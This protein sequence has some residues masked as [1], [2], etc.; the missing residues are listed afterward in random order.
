MRSFNNFLESQKYG[1]LVDRTARIMVEQQIDPDHYMFNYI[2]KN[3]PEV[4]N[5]N[6][7][8][9]MGTGLKNTWQTMKSGFMAN[10]I[11]DYRTVAKHLNYW[12]DVLGQ[13]D[14][15]GKL[16]D[17]AEKAMDALNQVTGGESGLQQISKDV[18]TRYI[19]QNPQA[20]QAQGD[21]QGQQGGQQNAQDPDMSGQDVQTGPNGSTVVTPQQQGGL[22]PS[23]DP[24]SAQAIV[25]GGGTPI[26]QADTGVQ[27]V[28][29]N[30]A[31]QLQGQ[32][33]QQQQPQQQPRKATQQDM[34]LAAYYAGQKNP[35]ASQ[36]DNWEAGKQALRQ[37]GFQVDHLKYPG[38]MMQESWNALDLAKKMG[39]C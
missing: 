35:H 5:E 16:K 6:W 12:K 23:V 22:D 34:Q 26:S 38:Q 28:D 25:G 15:T 29:P 33:P 20:A 37:Q 8:S 3:H 2:K 18:Q 36:Q 24:S 1:D 9:R 27:Y 31:A 17:A 19:A 4:V 7:F 13:Y 10:P 14:T 30:V 39:L 11:Q 21:I 32:Q